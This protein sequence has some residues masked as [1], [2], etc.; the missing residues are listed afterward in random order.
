ME[1][2]GKR[3]TILP[4][5]LGSNHLKPKGRGYHETPKEG[6]SDGSRD[7]ESRGDCAC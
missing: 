7:A 6:V 4:R 2:P 1:T 5:I 3:E